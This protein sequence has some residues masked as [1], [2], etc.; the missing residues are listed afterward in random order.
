MVPVVN[1][2]LAKVLKKTVVNGRV[3]KLKDGAV[4]ELLLFLQLNSRR[5]V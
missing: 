3:Y 2:S 1:F 5:L 4:C